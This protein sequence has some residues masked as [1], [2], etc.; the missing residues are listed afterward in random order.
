MDRFDPSSQR[1][2]VIPTPPPAPAI[3]GP[4]GSTRARLLEAAGEVFAERGFKDATVREICARAGANIAAINYYFQGKDSLYLH[5]I[6]FATERVRH[7]RPINVDP[8]APAA[9]RLRQFLR[10]F[11]A[12]VLDPDSPAWH[13]KLVEPSPALDRVVANTI[14]PTAMLLTGI[15]NDIVPGLNEEQ[16]RYCTTSVMGQCLMHRHCEPVLAR[17]FPQFAQ[18]SMA[19]LERLSDHV[20]RFSIAGLDAVRVSLGHPPIAASAVARH[21]RKPRG[22]KADPARTKPRSRR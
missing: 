16:L 6:D 19:D 10:A 14:R 13:A 5:V 20:Y 21:A 17:M 22:A 8:G 2:R 12:R 1:A 7:A 3:V 18:R 15:I 4:E 11:V 9:E